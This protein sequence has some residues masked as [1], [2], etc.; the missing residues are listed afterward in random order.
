M[1]EME[2]MTQLCH[3]SGKESPHSNLTTSIQPHPSNKS[4]NQKRCWIGSDPPA[5][6]T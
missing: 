1:T 5:L 4:S 2:K 3:L 6:P